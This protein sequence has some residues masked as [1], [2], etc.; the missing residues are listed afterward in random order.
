VSCRSGP[1][2]AGC[3]GETGAGCALRQ[4]GQA[5]AEVAER[6][7]EQPGDVPLGDAEL[8]ADLG[9]CHVAVKAHQQD[10][11]L[12]AGQLPATMA[13]TPVPA[14]GDVL[15]RPTAEECDWR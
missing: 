5:W 1:I 2:H 10:L 15:R 12:T 11:L 9:L 3:L 8:L 7:G 4:A 14:A 6:A 13:G